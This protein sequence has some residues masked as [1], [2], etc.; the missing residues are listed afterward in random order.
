[1]KIISNLLFQSA[2]R[3]EYTINSCGAGCSCGSCI[4]MSSHGAPDT[5][6][7][8]TMLLICCWHRC[9]RYTVHS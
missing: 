6:T 1:M 7:A 5:E 4:V 3:H 2:E 8:A 9:Q